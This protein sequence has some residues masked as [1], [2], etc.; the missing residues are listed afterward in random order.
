MPEIIYLFSFKHQNIVKYFEHFATNDFFYLVTEYC[1]VRMSITLV[2]PKLKFIINQKG[3]DLEEYLENNR[4]SRK[5]VLEWFYQIILGVQYLH[6]ND[7]PCI[8]RDLKP[9]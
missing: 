3:G 2:V 1:E 4:F 6:N 9:L 8:H 7:P 5:Q